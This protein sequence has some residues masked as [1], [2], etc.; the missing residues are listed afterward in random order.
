M[1]ILNLQA[2]TPHF[3]ILIMTNN[4]RLA[5]VETN[6]TNI[7]EDISEIKDLLNK[8]IKQGNKMYSNIDKRYAAKWV[9]K[10]VI[11]SIV[12]TLGVLISLIKF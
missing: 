2:F 9:E 7:K 10:I 1:I 4:E 6:I 11:A 8:Q 12:L 5:S 3:N